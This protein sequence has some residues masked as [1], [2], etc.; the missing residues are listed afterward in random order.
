MAYNDCGLSFHDIAKKLNH[1]FSLINVFLKKIGN[2]QK[3]KMLWPQEKQNTAS[4]D[5]KI[6]KTAKWQHTSKSQ[7]LKFKIKYSTE[8]Y[9]MLI[10]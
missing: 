4:Q 6:V 8:N 9:S 1:H 5:R 2:Y 3:K 10:A 7:H